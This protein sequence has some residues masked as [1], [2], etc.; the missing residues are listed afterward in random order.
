MS[1]MLLFLSTGFWAQTEVWVADSRGRSSHSS[2]DSNHVLVNPKDPSK[3]GY[4]GRP[5]AWCGLEEPKLERQ[6]WL[7]P[8]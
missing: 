3:Q 2:G 7:A 8:S 4:L 6:I 5:A 1:Y